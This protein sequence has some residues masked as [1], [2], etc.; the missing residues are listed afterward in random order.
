[1]VLALLLVFAI[2]TKSVSANANTGTVVL[3]NEFGGGAVFSLN[4]SDDDELV[5]KCFD[6]VFEYQY[7]YDLRIYRLL[8]VSFKLKLS[9]NGQNYMEEL[10]YDGGSQFYAD[11][12][13][14]LNKIGIVLDFT[15]F[16]SNDEISVNVVLLT[17][18][19]NPTIYLSSYY[20]QMQMQ[21]F[22]NYN[23]TEIVFTSP[24]NYRVD[25]LEGD[26]QTGLQVGL[27]NG[28]N[29]GY[30]EGYGVGEGIGYQNGY[31]DG[32]LTAD[33]DLTALFGGI[34]DT[35]YRILFSLLSFDVFGISFYSILMSL[36]TILIIFWLIRKF[37]RGD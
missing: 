23:V 34:A 1:M 8:S 7:N 27:Q 10:K 12:T 3:E 26:Y 11:N 30:D 13:I 24:N 32:L 16:L 14:G 29:N 17:E 4:G 6:G 19:Y 35:P 33:N 18:D 36:L 37:A 25:M 21:E 2:P 31:N 15:E 22:E 28:Y 20:F 9:A 5:V